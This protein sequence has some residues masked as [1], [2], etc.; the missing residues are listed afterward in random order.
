METKAYSQRVGETEFAVRYGGRPFVGNCWQL[1]EYVRGVET[2]QPR[3]YASE[4]AA[5]RAY[6][7]AIKKAS[8]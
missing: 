3:I 5:R 4:K 6:L 2:G 7:R 1:R 8:A